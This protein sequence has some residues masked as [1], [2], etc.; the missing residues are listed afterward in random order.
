MHDNDGP[1]DGVVNGTK[2]TNGSKDKSSK[3]RVSVSDEP[4]TTG[5]KTGVESELLLLSLFLGT[6]DSAGEG[7]MY[8]VKK[9]TKFRCNW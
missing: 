5:P 4:A 2:G 8:A 7:P 6:V 1:D 9:S 3:V